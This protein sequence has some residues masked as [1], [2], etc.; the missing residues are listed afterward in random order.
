[1]FHD[2]G[3]GLSLTLTNGAVWN[4]TETSYLTELVVDESSTVNGVVTETADGIIVEP[5]A[6]GAL[7]IYDFDGEA[8]VAL[9]AL[10][11]ILGL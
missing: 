11:A 6:E 9:D 3:S 10:K 4:V 1:M 8:Y 7:E 2:E 5:M